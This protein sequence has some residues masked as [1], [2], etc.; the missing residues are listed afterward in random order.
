[1]STGV[2]TEVSTIQNITEKLAELKVSFPSE[3]CT[4]VTTM[5]NITGKIIKLKIHQITVAY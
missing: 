5:L 3:V 4:E 2:C 1:M